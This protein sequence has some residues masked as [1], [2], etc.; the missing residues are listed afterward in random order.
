MLRVIRTIQNNKPMKRRDKNKSGRS[1]EEVESERVIPTRWVLSLSRRNRQHA[2][3]GTSYV[4]VPKLARGGRESQKKKRKW[5]TCSQSEWS[6]MIQRLY[7]SYTHAHT[8]SYAH[9]SISYRQQP[10]SLNYH[11]ITYSYRAYIVDTQTHRHA[12]DV[13]K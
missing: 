10:R 12:D 7:Y 1:G 3:W 6:C 4:L 11:A 9:A 8:Y 13:Y 5:S 2:K